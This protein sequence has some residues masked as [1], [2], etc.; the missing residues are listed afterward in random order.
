MSTHLQYPLGHPTRS[1]LSTVHIH[2]QDLKSPMV[3]T[4]ALT[5]L[6]RLDVL[7]A[8]HIQVWAAFLLALAAQLSHYSIHFLCAPREYVSAWA[9]I[10]ALAVPTIEFLVVLL[11]R[12][13]S[14]Q[15]NI[16]QGRIYLLHRTWRKEEVRFNVDY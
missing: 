13:L 6:C 11:H 12:M 8:A 2:R 4:S 14:Q 15:S 7:V 9:R 10:P 16:F 1:T 3:R 5:T